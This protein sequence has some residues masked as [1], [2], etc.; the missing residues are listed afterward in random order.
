MT[1]LQKILLEILLFILLVKKRG[2]VDGALT[3]LTKRSYRRGMKR[4]LLIVS[5]ILEQVN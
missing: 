1:S 4:V 5:D 3:P 2:G